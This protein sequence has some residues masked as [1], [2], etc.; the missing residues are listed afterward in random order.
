MA[1]KYP[2]ETR[3]ERI[4][5]F[6]ESNKT[7]PVELCIAIVD[8]MWDK[9]RADIQKLIP[10]RFKDACMVELGEV[11][12]VINKTIE[13]IFSGKKENNT[14]GMILAGPAGSGKTHAMYAIL[15]ALAEKNP[16]RI[17][18]V[19]NYPSVIQSLRKEFANDSYDELGSTWDKLNDHSG[20]Y[21]GMIFLDDV[22]STKITDFEA[23]KLLSIIDH[24][25]DEYL[26]FLITTNILPEEF[27]NVFGE[28]IA[29]RLLGYCELIEFNENDQR[30]VSRMK[31]LEQAPES[32]PKNQD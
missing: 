1:S 32:K 13:K 16:E 22:S 29:S 17:V 7:R 10:E 25:T 14:V 19:G 23:D 12:S 4:D 2:L 15:K 8:S 24:R 11:E 21:Q 30:I 3:D 26:P 6:R 31:E 27:L 20:L 5:R 28:R 18:F 9:R